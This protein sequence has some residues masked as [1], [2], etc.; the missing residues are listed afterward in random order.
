MSKLIVLKGTKG[1]CLRVLDIYT[2]AR[3]KMDDVE[4]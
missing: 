4:S 3:S 2:K 1:A